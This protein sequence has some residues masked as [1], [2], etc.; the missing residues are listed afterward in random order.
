MWNDFYDKMM[1]KDLTDRLA[2]L[3]MPTFILWGDNDRILHVS[4]VEVYKR[5]V[6]DAHAVIMEDCGH[7]PMLERPDEA[8]EHYARFLQQVSGTN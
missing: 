8:A 2:E 7:V 5:L 4:S 1:E 3:K 6:P